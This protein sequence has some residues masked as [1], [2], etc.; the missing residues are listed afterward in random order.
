MVAFF[1][2]FIFILLAEMADKTQLLVMS[3][4]IR[5]STQKV[6]LAVCLA[7]ILNQ[8]IAVLIGQFLITI[9]PIDLIS[10]FA[11]I[12]FIVFG[13]WTIRGETFSGNTPKEYTYGSVVTIMLAFFLAE[14]GDK[15]QLATVSLAIKYQPAIYVLIGTTLGIVAANTFGIL[16]G[17]VIRKNVPDYIIQW[18]SAGLFILFGFLSVYTILSLY[19]A[20]IYLLAS[21]FFLVFITFFCTFYILKRKRTHS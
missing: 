11:A 12:S 20:F 21:M 18:I 8:T 4:A 16:L 6:F 3:F 17:K 14:I 1:T 7:T 2:S 5:Y 9:V 13:L 19:V 10:F 15:T